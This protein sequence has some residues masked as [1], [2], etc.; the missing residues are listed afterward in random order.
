GG[1]DW[2]RWEDDLVRQEAGAM[3]EARNRLG[4]AIGLHQFRQFL[5]FRQWRGVREYANSKGIRLIGDL[6]IFVSA[7][8][9][10]VW[11][12]AELFQLD[13][14]RRPTAVAGVPPD[15]FSSTGQLWGNPLYD[16]QKLK[17]RNYAWWLNRL[18][19]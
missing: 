11:A 14:A 19:A 10:D 3:K 4:D 1:A 9:S 13:E 8:S 15:Y 16:W 5:F 18:R 12:N 7:D 6:P 17:D 2:T